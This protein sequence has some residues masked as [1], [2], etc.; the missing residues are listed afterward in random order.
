MTAAALINAL[1][2][3]G[4]TLASAKIVCLGAGS[5]AIAGALLVSLGANAE[6][7]VMLD[8]LGVIYQGREEVNEF[9]AEFALQTEARTLDDACVDA[10]VLLVFRAEFTCQ[11]HY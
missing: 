6:N 3:Q 9:K 1:E 10:D 2:L 4:K 11:K 7:I 5:A 8:R